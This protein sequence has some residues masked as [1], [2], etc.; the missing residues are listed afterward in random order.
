MFDFSVT[1]HDLILMLM[2]ILTFVVITRTESGKE[3]FRFWFDAYRKARKPLFGRVSFSIRRF[4]VE[5]RLS[6][7]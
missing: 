1:L 4:D 5:G 6:L 2:V 3:L 7:L